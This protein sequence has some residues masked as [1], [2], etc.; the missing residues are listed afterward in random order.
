M[1][2]FQNNTKMNMLSPIKSL[3]RMFTISLQR[4]LS[5][6]ALPEHI[7]SICTFL[8]NSTNYLKAVFNPVKGMHRVSNYF[9]KFETESSISIQQKT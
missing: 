9:S 3:D 2:I 7:R 4:T 8:G 6:R 1:V 5:R